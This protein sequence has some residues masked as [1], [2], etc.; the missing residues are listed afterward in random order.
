MISDL[1]DI[2]PLVCL[3]GWKKT[4][5]GL[6]LEQM[7]ELEGGVIRESKTGMAATTRA[8][9]RKQQEAPDGE[10]PSSKESALVERL[11]H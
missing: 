8:D 10:K 6:T 11:I 9:R 4:K 5:D 2:Q 3:L 1:V 7:E